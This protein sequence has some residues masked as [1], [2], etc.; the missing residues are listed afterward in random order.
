[1]SDKK[2]TIKEIKK[3]YANAYPDK[4]NNFDSKYYKKKKSNNP[5]SKYYKNKKSD[6]PDS[7]YYK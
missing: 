2:I 5:D 3:V 7:K 1:M 4:T 6:N